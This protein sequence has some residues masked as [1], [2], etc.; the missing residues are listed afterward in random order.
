MTPSQTVVTARM[1]LQSRW[2]HGVIVKRKNTEDEPVFSN[3]QEER[4]M[5]KTYGCFQITFDHYHVLRLQLTT[6]L[7]RAFDLVYFLLM[8]DK[9]IKET[10]WSKKLLLTS[11]SPTKFRMTSGTY[12]NES[13]NQRWSS[14]I[15]ATMITTSTRLQLRFADIFCGSV[16]SLAPYS[17]VYI[18]T[19]MSVSYIYVSYTCQRF[20]FIARRQGGLKKRRSRM[21]LYTQKS[22][23]NK[24]QSHLFKLQLS[25]CHLFWTSR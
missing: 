23:K 9:N 1:N 20:Y 6:N 21:A 7:A 2:C 19:W 24:Q 16:Y 18:C 12:S 13:W 3:Q 4:W 22:P 15:V 14:R 25:I 11:I 5:E 10:A 8:A 17:F